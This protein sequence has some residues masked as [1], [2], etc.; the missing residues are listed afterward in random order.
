[1]RIKMNKEM[2]IYVKMKMEIETNKLYKKV[3]KITT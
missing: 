3:N 1:M 2:V